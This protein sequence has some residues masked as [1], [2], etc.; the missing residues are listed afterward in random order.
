MNYKGYDVRLARSTGG[1]AGRGHNKTSTVQ[2][3]KDSF[4][5]K[6][7]RYRVGDTESYVRA[8]QKAWQ[9]VDAHARDW[10]DAQR[11]DGETVRFCK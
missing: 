6:Q 8:E 11:N 2:V 5:K 7:F 10:A 3:F 4:L 9:W 1:K